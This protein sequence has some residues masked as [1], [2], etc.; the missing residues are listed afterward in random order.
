MQSKPKTTDV[1]VAKVV[2][3]DD[4]NEQRISRGFWRDA[5]RRLRRNKLALIG[6]AVIVINVVLA[7]LAPV[8]TA[9]SFSE[10]NRDRNNAAPVWV[11][12]LFPTMKPVQEDLWTFEGTQGQEVAIAMTSADLDSS[13]TLLDPDGSLIKSGQKKTVTI[14]QPPDLGSYITKFALPMDGQYTLVA[15]SSN[16]GL[17]GTYA[18]QIFTGAEADQV[19][20]LPSPPPAAG[21]PATVPAA[22]EANRACA[23][24]REGRRPCGTLEAGQIGG[25]FVVG[26]GYVRE[27]EAREYPLGAD[28]LGRDLLTRI[29]YGARISLAVAFVGPFVSLIVGIL[30]GLISGYVGGRVD[31]GL[32]RLVDIMYA[33]PTILFV[34]LMMAYFRASAQVEPFDSFLVGVNDWVGVEV[35]VNPRVSQPETLI[36]RLNSIDAYFGGMMFIF[37]GIGLTSWMQTTRLTRAQVLSVR[38][39]EYIEAAVSIG[40]SNRMIIFRHV[41]PNILGPIIVAETLTIPT[42][43][44]YEAF[45]SFIGLGVNRPTPSWGAMISDGSSAIASY[46]NQAIFPAVALFFIMFAFNFLGDGLRDALDPRTR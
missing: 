5:W 12:T 1:P 3:L 22:L 2:S 41:L 46:P 24:E 17:K 28:G 21:Q 6:I 34:I 33:F 30:L 11:T 10:Q 18:L 19:S 38:S 26:D 9:K 35:L 27:V 14:G 37:I 16:V 40:T 36:S 43:I 44:S 4:L 20:V 42:Y 8:I 32:M 45:L 15:R 23:S 31:N 39:K 13:I 25:N 7:L 29:I